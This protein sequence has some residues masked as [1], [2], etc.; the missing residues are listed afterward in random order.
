MNILLAPLNPT[1]VTVT[2][3]TILIVSELFRGMDTLDRI[4]MVLD[5]LGDETTHNIQA[6]TPEELLP[7][8][9]ERYGEPA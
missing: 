6:L 7:R 8:G 4:D 2:N 9:I 1:Q 5:L 3:D